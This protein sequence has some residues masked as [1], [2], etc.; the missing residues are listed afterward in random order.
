MLVTLRFLVALL[1]S[2]TILA[3][4]A[5]AGITSKNLGNIW[6]IGDSITQSNADDS[7]SSSPRKSLYDKLNAA[8][9]YTFAYTGHSTSNLDGLPSSPDTY[10]YHS[11][12]SGSLIGNDED[13]RAGH[14]QR[15]PTWWTQGKLATNKPNVILIMLGTNDIIVPVDLR[16]APTRMNTLLNTIFALPNIGSP[17]VFVSTIPPNKYVPEAPA[18]IAAF[19]A[20]LPAII[21]AQRALGRDVTLVDHFTPLNNAYAT[22]IKASDNLHPNTVGNNIIG[23]TWFDAIQA[24]AVPEPG[25][26]VVGGSAVLAAM[27]VRR[28]RVHL[29]LIAARSL[30]D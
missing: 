24:R 28:K 7:S 5:S 15:I 20:A 13:P 29:P 27:L 9:G 14:T 23:Q 3:T 1:A 26:E 10:R 18:R 4:Q 30:A 22:A 8:G 25:S 17:S 2:A 19:N 6:F 12:V 21:E 11:G 16:S